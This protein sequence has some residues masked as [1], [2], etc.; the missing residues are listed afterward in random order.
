MEDRMT[1]RQEVNRPLAFIIAAGYVLFIGL[2][3]LRGVQRQ[4]LLLAAP[5]RKTGLRARFRRH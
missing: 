5:G 2:V 1:T 3:L 4:R